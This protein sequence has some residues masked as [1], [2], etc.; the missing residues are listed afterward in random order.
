MTWWE[1]L[2]IVAAAGYAVAVVV[3]CIVRKKQGKTSCDCGC[4]S[5]PH[6]AACGT[7]KEGDPPQ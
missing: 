5:C 1:I 3:M 4:A 6:C 2:L 7:K